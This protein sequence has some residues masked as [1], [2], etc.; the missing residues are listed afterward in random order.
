MVTMR[1]PG[2]RSRDFSTS[3]RRTRRECPLPLT[4]SPGGGEESNTRLVVTMRPEV[5]VYRHAAPT[6]LKRAIGCY[7]LAAFFACCAVSRSAAA[8]NEFQLR[9]IADP[10]RTNQMLVELAGVNDAALQAMRS[11]NWNAEKWQK[12]FTVYAEQGDLT[13]DSSLPPMLGSYQIAG[14]TIQFKPRFAL[15]PGIS[16]RAV[17]RP[18]RLP[19]EQSI[20]RK[21]VISVFELAKPPSEATT[22]VS[23]VYPTADALPE[24]LLKFYIYFSAPMSRG[25]IYE[26]LHLRDE[27]GKAI[28]LPFLEIDEEFWDRSMMRLTLFIDPGRIKRGVK[29]LEEIGPALEAGKRYS[30]RIDREWKDASGNPL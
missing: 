5:G 6:E 9:W 25:H 7:I 22:V 30:L 12:L 18:D 4:L 28:E 24:N 26:Y 8:E 29:P 10:A 14:R 21:P 2:W 23:Q 11:D 16:Y 19:L 17:F 15:E 20:P 27:A 3:G 13:V 1:V